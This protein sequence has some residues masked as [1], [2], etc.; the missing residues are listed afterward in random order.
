[1]E[2]GA[3]G[4]LAFFLVCGLLAAFAGIV[5]LLAP[6]GGEPAARESRDAAPEPSTVA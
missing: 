3:T 6:P 5:Y 4:G 2:P 1:L